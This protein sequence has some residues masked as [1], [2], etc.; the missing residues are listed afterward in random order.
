MPKST[1]DKHLMVVNGQS[2]CTSTFM[3]Q[4]SVCRGIYT[5]DWVHDKKKIAHE[6]NLFAFGALQL[7][8]REMLS[9]EIVPVTLHKLNP[10]ELYNTFH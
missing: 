5:I 8:D 2:L 6:V 9:K 7:L 3:T 1:C 4:Y 10:A